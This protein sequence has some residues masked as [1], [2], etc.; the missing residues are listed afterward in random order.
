MRSVFDHYQLTA[1]YHYHVLIKYHQ[2]PMRYQFW[3]L[4]AQI[5][6]RRRTSQAFIKHINVL[7]FL[8]SAP[9]IIN[10]S[11]TAIA[12]TK[13]KVST[14]FNLLI[15]NNQTDLFLLVLLV[16]SSLLYAAD[17]LINIAQLFWLSITVYICVGKEISYPEWP[18]SCL[19]RPAGINAIVK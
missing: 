11:M 15:Q 13:I 16:H 14:T 3:T 1:S 7:L 2:L 5:N 17:A 6:D 12:N 8:V 18:K 4:P 10:A 19:D 9:W